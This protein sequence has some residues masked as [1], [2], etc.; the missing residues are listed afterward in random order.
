[1]TIATFG[2]A[3]EAEL[4]RGYL[5]SG[6]IDVFL[7][8]Q[9]ISRVAPHYSRSFGEIRLQVRQKDAAE[10]REILSQVRPD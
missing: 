8:D 4:A 2:T 7:A 3:H 6:G 5:E 9:V 10:A 1:M